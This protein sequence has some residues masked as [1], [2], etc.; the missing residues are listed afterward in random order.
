[1]SKRPSRTKIPPEIEAKMTLAVKRF[2]DSLVDQTQMLTEQTQSVSV[3]VR[4]LFQ[5]SRS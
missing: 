3:Q 4:E 5:K 2:V 1:M